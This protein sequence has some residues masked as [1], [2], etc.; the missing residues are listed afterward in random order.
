MV[1]Y[2]LSSQTLIRLMQIMQ[3]TEHGGRYIHLLIWR[4]S[5]NATY[6]GLDNVTINNATITVKK[7]DF[8]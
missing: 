8:N 5:V 3:A 6:D 7:P 1:N 4:L 2:Y